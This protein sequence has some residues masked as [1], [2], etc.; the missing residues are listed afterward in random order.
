LDEWRSSYSNHPPGLELN[1]YRHPCNDKKYKL[2]PRDGLPAVE[3]LKDTVKRVVPFWENQIIRK[4]QNEKRVIIVS[5]KNTLRAFFQ[6]LQGI[7]DE[8]IK[9]FK[10]PNALPIVYEFDEN[11]KHVNNYCLMDQEAHIVR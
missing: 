7:S 1:D 5:H 8:E 4:V 3:S 2:I 10:V 6:H 11:M 9:K